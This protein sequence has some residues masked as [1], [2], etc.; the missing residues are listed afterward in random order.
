MN[1][2]LLSQSERLS[3]W[4]AF[5]T[6]LSE[7]DEVTQVQR[8][9]DYWSQAPLMAYGHDPEK[10]QDWGSPWEMIS[11]GRWCRLS[12]AIG[13]EFTLRLA[14]WAPE[15]LLL[16]YFNDRDAQDMFFVLKIDGNRI[17]NYTFKSIEEELKT[18]RIIVCRWQFLDRFYRSPEC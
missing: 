16:E 14:G 3:D 15:R 4:K 1:P 11:D 9:V 7:D 10:P 13:M 8:V 12:V 18:N 5:R 6:S 2:F 17:L